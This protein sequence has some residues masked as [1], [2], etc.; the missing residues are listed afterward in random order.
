MTLLE[1]DRGVSTLGQQVG[2][3]RELSQIARTARE[4]GSVPDPSV[5]ERIT[6][7]WAGLRVIRA[8]ALRT[9]A[10]R[11]SSGG[12]ASAAKLLWANWHRDLGELAMQVRG[13]ASLTGLTH[14]TEGAANDL[15]D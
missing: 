10:E 15:H 11:D 8:H 4:K 2:F 5:R 14:T 9:L 13:A 6:A 12:D 1:F 3:A 7:A